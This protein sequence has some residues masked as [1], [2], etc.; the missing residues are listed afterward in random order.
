MLNFEVDEEDE[1]D[2]D[3]DEDDEP[4]LGARRPIARTQSDPRPFPRSAPALRARGR[5]ALPRISSSSS[6]DSLFGRPRAASMSPNKRV[7]RRR[8]DE[9]Y[10]NP[11]KTGPRKADGRRR[12][13]V[14]REAGEEGPRGRGGRRKAM[15]KASSFVPASAS[16]EQYMSSDSSEGEEDSDE[17]VNRGEWTSAS[18]VAG[19]IKTNFPVRTMYAGVDGSYRRPLVDDGESVIPL[20]KVFQPGDV[21]YGKIRGWRPW[22]AVVVAPGEIP[23]CV[24]DAMPLDPVNEIAFCFVPEG[25]YWK[26]TAEIVRPLPREGLLADLREITLFLGTAANR[27]AARGKRRRATQDELLLEGLK[28]ALSPAALALWR[29]KMGKVTR[30][31]NRQYGPPKKWWTRREI[32]IEEHSQE[33]GPTK[34]L[35]TALKTE[36]WIRPGPGYDSARLIPNNLQED[37]KFIDED[38]PRLHYN[39]DLFY[40]ADYI[41]HLHKDEPNIVLDENVVVELPRRSRAA[42]RA[43]SYVDLPLPRRGSVRKREAAGRAGARASD[44]RMGAQSGLSERARGKQRARS[45]LPDDDDDD[46]E[47]EEAAAAAVGAHRSQARRTWANGVVAAAADGDDRY[48]DDVFTWGDSAGRSARSSIARATPSGGRKHGGSEGRKDWVSPSS[49]SNA[50]HSPD[51]SRSR[52]GESSVDV[53]AAATAAANWRSLFDEDS[54]DEAEDDGSKKREEEEEEDE[55]VG[56]SRNRLAGLGP[57]GFTPM[58]MSSGART[59]RYRSVSGQSSGGEEEVW[60]G[61]GGGGAYGFGASWGYGYGMYGSGSGAGGGSG[62][63]SGGAGNNSHAPVFGAGYMLGGMT[64]NPAGHGSG[65]GGGGARTPAY[66]SSRARTPAHTH[67]E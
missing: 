2:E 60:R 22:P 58:A 37:D 8:E 61:L 42:L 53:A 32:L 26:G 14:R 43:F 66:P 54:D 30:A 39:Q 38:D 67:L 24:R 27:A 12:K 35:P 63:G 47:E 13:R 50:S 45:V 33:F 59:P 29:R 65:G 6:S 57:G 3:D 1:D 56:L 5:P 51:R 36:R 7:V 52:L 40:H 28:I 4:I 34:P 44:G 62:S 48:D 25:N 18:G 17:L 46:E 11:R 31:S 20:S 19:P 49:S 15:I 10:V 21:I 41:F 16:L 64:P 23:F 9:E 55:G